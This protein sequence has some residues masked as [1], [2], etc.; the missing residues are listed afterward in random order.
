MPDPI[1]NKPGV[2]TPPTD[3]TPQT[4]APAQ[5]PKSGKGILQDS[6]PTVVDKVQQGT[7]SDGIQAPQLPPPKDV[8]GD[9]IK[10]AL[11]FKTTSLKLQSLQQAPDMSSAM[12]AMQMISDQIMQV[13]QNMA[14]LIQQMAEQQ[15][16]A[17][18]AAQVAHA[19]QV[20]ANA[21]HHKKEGAVVEF[22][23]KIFM[24]GK[25]AQEQNA[26]AELKQQIGDAQTVLQKHQEEEQLQQQE[27]SELEQDLKIMEAL[28]KQLQQQSKQASG[29]AK[30]KEPADASILD[31]LALLLSG[32]EDELSGSGGGD[33]TKLKQ[34]ANSRPWSAFGDEMLSTTAKDDPSD[35]KSTDTLQDTIDIMHQHQQQ[36]QIIDNAPSAKPTRTRY[37]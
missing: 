36:Q 25:Y 21:G 23:M 28:L 7:P 31:R 1:S 18:T 34:S 30:S 22:L 33:D 9:G 13:A 11:D 17:P 15:K 5:D 6:A 8:S 32:L 14:V 37:I 2:Y 24:P 16:Q 3:Q 20:L 26:E 29:T 35:L 19:K 10:H 12:A 4:E 27:R